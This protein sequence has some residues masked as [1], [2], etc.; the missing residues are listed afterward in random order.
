MPRTRFALRAFTLSL[1][2]LASAHAARAQN[3]NSIRGKIRDSSGNN[4]PRV[5][6]DL[7]TGNGAAVDQTTANNEGDFSFIGLGGIS[8]V[9]T[10]R[11][12]GY[13]P[14]SEAVEFVNRA[15]GD[16]P[17]ELRTVEVILMPSGEARPGAPRPGRVSVAQNVPAP[18]REAFE[19]GMKL[20]REGK[21]ADAEAA[22]RES[23]TAFPD[24]F[25][26]RF[27]LANELVRTDRLDD[28][29]QHLEVARRVS[30]ADER[31]YLLF[32]HL[33]SLK[34]NYA[35]A[36]AVFAEAARVSPTDPQPLL[37]RGTAL[38]NY[39]SIIDAAAS[40]KAADERR[41]VLDD[42]EKALNESYRL[43]GK[44]LSDVLIQLARV[45]EK[46]G[47]LARAADELELYL[48]QNPNAPN[49][50][51]LRDAVKTLRAPK[52]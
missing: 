26:A 14:A 22:V 12:A 2:L 44:K 50:P 4:V 40:K 17:G 13:A 34:K 41:A 32:G 52:Q 6:V 30:P 9:V 42:A 47:D 25:D 38:V 37:R 43:S 31:V 28:A 11:A 24:Y 23:I 15:G 18:A 45:Y 5:T 1:L 51:A 33:L 48:R 3:G 39:A 49:A 16:Q 27:W 7:Q 10:I 21:A 29:V 35:V 36:A 8:Y 20:S 19:R 46:R